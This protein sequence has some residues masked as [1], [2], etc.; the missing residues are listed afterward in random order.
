MKTRTLGLAAAA[1]AVISVAGEAQA[2]RVYSYVTDQAQYNSEPGQTRAVKFFLREQL[3][4]GDTSLINS[5]NGLFGVGLKVV[6]SGGGPS[7]PSI[8]GTLTVNTQDFGG[9]VIKNEGAA[10]LSFSAGI[11][12][13]A[14]T[15]VRPG[16]T[17]GGTSPGTPAD[18]V[19]LGSVQVTAGSGPGVT[20]FSLQPYGTGG[21]TLTNNNFYDLDFSSTNPAYSGASANPTSF[22]MNVA[23]PEPA[24]VGVVAVA[25]M[26]GLLRRRRRTLTAC[27]L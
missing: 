12:P 16:N 3:T 13:T 4:G 6:R 21:D 17:A 25:G 18:M 15:G 8:L 22:S 11:A 26:A 7:T 23:V 27:T 20:S 5:D 9:P 2:A 24:G 1:M 14:T 10:G 19:Y